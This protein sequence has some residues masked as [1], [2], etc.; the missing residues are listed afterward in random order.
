M[1]WAYVISVH[2]SA[3]DGVDDVVTSVATSIYGELGFDDPD[4]EQGEISWDGECSRIA[5]LTDAPIST[6]RRIRSVVHA[7][8]SGFE[9]RVTYRRLARDAQTENRVEQG[10]PVELLFSSSSIARRRSVS[11]WSHQLV[12]QFPWPVGD[13]ACFDRVAELELRIDAVLSA[14]DDD[15]VDGHDAGSGE[16]NIFILSNTPAHTFQRIRPLI[17]EWAPGA[18]VR[19]AYRDIDGE[20]FTII[21]PPDLATFDV[22]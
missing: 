8:A 5:V 19:A 14:A 16:L 13:I 12:I 9:Y 10:A 3:V 20:T 22:I 11:P 1:D 4:G 17:E 6:F 7:A 18:N 15:S 2:F 21:W